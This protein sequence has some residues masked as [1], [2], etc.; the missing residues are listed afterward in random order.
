MGESKISAR[1]IFEKSGGG[2]PSLFAHTIKDTTKLGTRKFAS[3]KKYIQPDVDIGKNI[4]GKDADLEG[5]GDV[6]K[7]VKKEDVQVPS[8]AVR[9]HR[10]V[11]QLSGRFGTSGRKKSFDIFSRIDDAIDN[12]PSEIAVEKARERAARKKVIDDAP[13]P[14]TLERKNAATECADASPAAVPQATASSQGTLQEDNPKDVQGEMN[15]SQTASLDRSADVPDP[16]SR[17]VP[18]LFASASRADK[19]KT[20][21][22]KLRL[23]EQQKKQ[24]VPAGSDDDNSRQTPNNPYSKFHSGPNSESLKAN[25]TTGLQTPADNHNDDDDFSVSISSVE[26]ESDQGQGQGTDCPDAGHEHTDPKPLLGEPGMPKGDTSTTVSL[27]EPEQNEKN[28]MIATIEIP[29]NLV[30]ISRDVAPCEVN[31]GEHIDAHRTELQ[32]HTDSTPFR[33][34]H[35]SHSP[36]NK[37][38]IKSNSGLTTLSH[39][40]QTLHEHDIMQSKFVDPIFSEEVPADDVAD[41]PN[42]EVTPNTS[43]VGGNSL[44]DGEVTGVAGQPQ[45]EKTKTVPNFSSWD[46]AIDGELS[47]DSDS[48]SESSSMSHDAV[49]LEQ[50][51]APTIPRF[52]LAPLPSNDNSSLPTFVPGDLDPSITDAASLR[53]RIQ[54]TEKLLEATKLNAKLQMG[55]LRKSFENAKNSMKLV[56]EEKISVHRRINMKQDQQ[57][58]KVMDE[59][60]KIVENLR[61]EN[62]TLRETKDKYPQQI[63]AVKKSIA[64]LESANEEVSKHFTELHAFTRKLQADHNKLFESSEQCKNEYLPRYRNELR[65]RQL[66]L[67]TETKVKMLYRDCTIRIAKHIEKRKKP[68]LTAMVNDMILETE[69]TVNPKF[70]PRL[71]FASD[72]D[73]SSSSDSSSDDSDSD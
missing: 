46:F 42:I 61:S 58:K 64:S 5:L 55:E 4:V 31:T 57:H 25:R 23:M 50:P 36:A 40:N 9:K 34:S 56:F 13:S 29:G 63:A 3:K 7:K 19:V 44:S 69:A 11:K 24:A 17:Q 6:I 52:S 54:E 1:K 14:R 41:A 12:D 30:A 60:K 67:D 43:K 26:S 37:G 48:D 71:L 72:S 35:R 15:S 39:A 27:V 10:M 47:D 8:G 32:C 22:W 68:E 16:E 49:D 20:P 53:Q 59:G 2:V 28:E 70:D 38:K 45:K 73:S 65:E 62:K 51:P 66:F 33:A 18:A 21:L